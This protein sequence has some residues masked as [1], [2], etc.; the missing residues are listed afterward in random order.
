MEILPL[1]LVRETGWQLIERLGKEGVA[2][3][4]NNEF[5]QGHFI[6]RKLLRKN[7]FLGSYESISS[8]TIVL[9][10]YKPVE[11]WWAM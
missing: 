11:V 3:L 4:G 2:Q 5:A 6:V 1:T 10:R 8:E 7:K 9:H